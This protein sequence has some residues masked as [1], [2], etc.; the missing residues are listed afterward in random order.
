MTE[1]WNEDHP[2]RQYPF[3]HTYKCDSLMKPF[4]YIILFAILALVVGAWCFA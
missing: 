2:D 3:E 1:D 4:L